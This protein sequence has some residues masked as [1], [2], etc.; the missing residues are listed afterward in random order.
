MTSSG[1]QARSQRLVVVS[2][3][4]AVGKTA[5]AERVAGQL[6]VP[7]FGKDALKE[8]LFDALGTGDRAWSR[9]LGR[10]SV[11]L[12]FEISRRELR[13]RRSLVIEA[14]FDAVSDS[15]PL[16]GILEETSSGCVRV[17]CCCS[18]KDLAQR[19]HA[20]A[21]SGVR[22]TGHLDHILDDELAPILER[23]RVA[24]LDLPGPL[25]DADTTALDGRLLEELTERVVS[26][27]RRTGR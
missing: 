22:H 12:L 21:A 16:R 4:P 18:G 13:A 1:P 27:C 8:R 24:P 19:F 5:L 2:G 23:G 26:E 25:V 14:N 17:Q 9:S 10:A 3:P 20:R 11:W 15:E 6:G 7:C